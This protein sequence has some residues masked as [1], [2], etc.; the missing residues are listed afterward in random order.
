MDKRHFGSYLNSGHEGTNHGMKS[1]AGAVMPQHALN[2]SV[3]LLTQQGNMT[4]KLNEERV[5]FEVKAHKSWLSLKCGE[6]LPKKVKACK[7]SSGRDRINM[8]FEDDR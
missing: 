1:C 4:S 3:E 5:C 6:K 7:E 2:K 8:V